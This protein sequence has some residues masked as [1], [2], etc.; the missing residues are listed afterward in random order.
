LS[1]RLRTDIRVDGTG[2]VPEALL[3]LAGSVEPVIE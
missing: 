2:L 1:E 3:I